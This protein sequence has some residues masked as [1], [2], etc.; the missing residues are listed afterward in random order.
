MKRYVFRHTYR[1]KR[2]SFRRTVTTII[3][4]CDV[5]QRRNVLDNLGF[6]PSGCIGEIEQALGDIYLQPGIITEFHEI[7]SYLVVKFPDVHNDVLG[8]QAFES[9]CSYVSDFADMRSELGPLLN[10]CQV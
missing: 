1:M 2:Y 5:I 6:T 4:E 10:S 9:V 3:F 8:S 7:W